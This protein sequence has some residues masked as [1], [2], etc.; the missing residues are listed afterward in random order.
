MRLFV[1]LEVPPDVADAL[2]GVCPPDGR[3]IRRVGADDF[4]LTLH[5][6]G[7]A[8]PSV[9]ATML[10]GARAQPF[11]VEVAG[12]GQFRLR[13]G[14]RILWAGVIPVPGL[15]ALHSD[16]ANALAAGGIRLETR[17][18]RPH[19]TL[20]R[21]SRSIPDASLAALPGTEA[22]FGHMVVRR[23]H[24]YDRTP[25]GSVN[26]YRRLETFDLSG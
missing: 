20:A 2:S 22:S 14:Q 17:P 21:V 18:Y 10:S 9:I 25:P 7:Q 1:G 8:E 16:L 13:S 6:I 24:L 4:H 19:I 12:I 15:L 5:F 3:G 23:F 26:R 11:A